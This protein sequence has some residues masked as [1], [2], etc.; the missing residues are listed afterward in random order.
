MDNFIDSFNNFNND[1]REFLMQDFIDQYELYPDNFS[2]IYPSSYDSV[3][4]ATLDD[5]NDIVLTGETR[6]EYL[7]NIRVWE[8]ASAFLFISV[9]L[10]N[11]ITIRAY[12]FVISNLL[13]K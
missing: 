3:S 7:G 9:F 5:P 12:N 10:S 11:L 2:P 6:I 4:P 1:S 13:T 8:L